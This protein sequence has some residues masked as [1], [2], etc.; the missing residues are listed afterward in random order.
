LVSSEFHDF[1]LGSAGVAG[2]LIGLLFVAISV[3][4]GAANGKAGHVYQQVRAAAAMSMFIDALVV[5]LLALIPGGQYLANG[6]TALAIAGLTSTA[7][8]VITLVR[9][10]DPSRTAWET[11]RTL[12]LFAAV[13]AVYALQLASALQL[14]GSH[15]DNGQVAN[16]ATL[17][18]IM[19]LMGI[20]RAWEIVGATRLRMLDVLA[21]ESHAHP[22]SNAASDGAKR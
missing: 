10:H 5:S 18:I 14:N 20:T 22:A 13:T 19:F 15:A 2:A 16:Q 9:T 1:F 11:G 4:P 7:A 8:L 12:V 3:T 17:V 21:Q 6:S